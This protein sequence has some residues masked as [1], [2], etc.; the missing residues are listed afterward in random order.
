[1]WNKKYLGNSKFLVKA[2]NEIQ[3]NKILEISKYSS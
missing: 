3:E 1:M 2:Q